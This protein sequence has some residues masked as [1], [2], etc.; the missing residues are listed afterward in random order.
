VTIADISALS[1]A[2]LHICDIPKD[3][4]DLLNMAAAVDRRALHL[5]LDLRQRNDSASERAETSR[6]R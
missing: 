3:A 5:R 1:S 4:H 2:S 6:S